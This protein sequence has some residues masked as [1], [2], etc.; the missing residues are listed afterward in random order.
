MNL[1]I[2]NLPVTATEGDLLSLLRL[3]REDAT[4]RLRIF[5]RADRKGSTQRFGLVYVESDADLRKMLA[6]SR[7]AQLDGQRLNVREYYSR[8]A[9]NERRALNWRS[10]TWLHAERRSSER[11]SATT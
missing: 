7:D 9:G 10:R 5:K 3:P 4:R 2:G 11:R 6:R 1:F 8:A